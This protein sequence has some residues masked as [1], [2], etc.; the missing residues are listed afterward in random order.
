ME[1]PGRIFSV[2]FGLKCENGHIPELCFVASPDKMIGDVNIKQK[3]IVSADLTGSK[4]TVDEMEAL[5][6]CVGRF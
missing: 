2:L 6:A 1:H 5:I 4:A 3:A